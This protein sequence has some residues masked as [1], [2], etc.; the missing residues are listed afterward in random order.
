MKPVTPD[1]ALA[2]V[3]G[4]DPLPRTELTKKLWDYIKS[5]NLQNPENKREIIADA[6]LKKVFDGRDKVTMFEMTKLVSGHVVK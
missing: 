6:A 2:A 4:A 5:N 3:V 1:A